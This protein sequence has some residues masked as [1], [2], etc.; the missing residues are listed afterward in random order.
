M[1]CLIYVMGN[2]VARRGEMRVLR[3]FVVGTWSKGRLW[4][5]WR[6]CCRLVFVVEKRSMVLV[7][8]FGRRHGRRVLSWSESMI[9]RVV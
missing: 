6:R 9:A 8:G 3:L 1:E 2:L 5:F 4:V 7:K